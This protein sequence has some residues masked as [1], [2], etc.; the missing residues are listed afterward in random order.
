[1]VKRGLFS[2]EEKIILRKLEKEHE[3]FKFKM[4]S[5]PIGYVYDCCQKIMF[6]ESVYEYFL[7]SREALEKFMEVCS[8]E[9]GIIEALW[10]LF[11][12]TEYL[13]M[14]KWEDLEELLMVFESRKC[15]GAKYGKSEKIF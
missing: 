1:M 3:L 11:V 14:E 13:K 5:S 12:D 7:Y 15:G 6:Y 9:D 2:K 10:E 4:L 8:K